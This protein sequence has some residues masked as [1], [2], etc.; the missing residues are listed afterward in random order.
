M[1]IDASI[2]GCVVAA[3][4]AL[5]SI[6][7]HRDAQNASLKRRTL[8]TDLSTAMQNAVDRGMGLYPPPSYWD[9]KGLDK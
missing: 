9:Q 5:T 1:R 4:A 8:D 7:I 2:G 3:I 6:I